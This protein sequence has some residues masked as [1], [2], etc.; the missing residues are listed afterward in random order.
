M[1]Y[2]SDACCPFLLVEATSAWLMKYLELH[3][4]HTK[5]LRATPPKQIS[6]HQHRPK[7]QASLKELLEDRRSE[8]ATFCPMADADESSS[9]EKA[10]V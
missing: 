3:S 7:S 8:T 2:G 10:G 1:K 5:M 4:K 9:S 6:V